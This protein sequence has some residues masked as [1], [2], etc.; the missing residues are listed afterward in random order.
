MPRHYARLS[1][2][3]RQP[4]IVAC[5]GNRPVRFSLIC[6]HNTVRFAGKLRRYLRTHRSRLQRRLGKMEPRSCRVNFRRS[7][8]ADSA[9]QY[10]W[11]GRPEDCRERVQ[12]TDF[13]SATHVAAPDDIP[14]RPWPP[15]PQ[16]SLWRSRT[17][18]VVDDKLSQLQDIELSRTG[19]LK[20]VGL[21][22]GSWSEDT[23]RIRTFLWP[24][25]WA[26]IANDQAEAIQSRLKEL[27][28]EGTELVEM[29]EW[30][31]RSRV[32]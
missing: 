26:K 7:R 4:K 2:H 30:K 12:E 11:P 14:S 24:S 6:R 22:K 18:L 29:H 32:R 19:G 8:F 20:K 15:V 25:A 17:G 3:A 1:C 28:K 27:A 10:A 31:R 5:S 13:G 16:S 9:T 21:I 23:S